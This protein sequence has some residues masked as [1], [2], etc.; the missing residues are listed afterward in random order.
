MQL[1]P[2]VKNALSVAAAVAMLATTAFSQISIERQDIFKLLG[3]G[4][5]H[6]YTGGEGSMNIGQKGGP[7]V[8][9]FSGISLSSLEVSYGYNVS[10]IPNLAGRFP[11]GSVTMGD[12]PSTIEK[13]PVFIFGQDTMYVV[14]QA[15]VTPELRTVH[16][17]PP[18]ITMIYPT[19][20]GS[21][22][23]QMVQVVD[24]TFGTGGMVSKTDVSSSEEFTTIDGYGTL[25]LSGM[26]FS[27]IRIKKEHRGYGD[28]E[29]MYLAKEG[30][31]VGVGG[32]AMTDPDT[33]FVSGRGQILLPA[34]IVRVAQERSVPQEFNLQQNYPNP[35][36]P[37]TRLEF[38]LPHD[39]FV[40][41]EVYDVLGRS[42]A[43]LVEGDYAAGTHATTWAPGA[44]VSS[45][46]Y[47]VR[48]V[49]TTEGNE[50]ALVMTRS[51]ML[52]R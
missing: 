23:T 18:E 27:C 47:F 38:S 39:A 29:F 37:S 40:T 31:F 36:N 20:Y 17:F 35:F 21:S 48:F 34:S 50:A 14:G 49:A 42:V 7:N 12:S 45:G 43:S 2:Y 13:N 4:M 1:A 15:S 5:T 28:K 32:I 19:V 22:F 25:K 11:D 9:D 41:L 51:M 30:V 44:T 8:Y 46:V 3:P 6:Y 33:G 24:S 16:Y 26:E 10:A 52:M